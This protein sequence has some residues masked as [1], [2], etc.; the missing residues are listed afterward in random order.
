LGLEDNKDVVRSAFAPL[1][2]ILE[3]HDEL[4]GPD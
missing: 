3:R 4:Y 1:Q 2:E